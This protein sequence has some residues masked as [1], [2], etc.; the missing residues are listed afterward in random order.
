[1][2][3]SSKETQKQDNAPTLKKIDLYLDKKQSSTNTLQDMMFSR[4]K[5]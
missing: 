4:K 5:P 3:D 1:M 2:L